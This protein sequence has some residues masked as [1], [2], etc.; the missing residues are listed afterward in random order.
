MKVY[1]INRKDV[2]VFQDGKALKVFKEKKYEYVL[3]KVGED[4][5]FELNFVKKSE[6][7]RPLWWLYAALFWIIGIMGFCT[8]AYSKNTDS[9]N[10][11]M[12]YTGR[13]NSLRVTFY[14][15]NPKYASQGAAL[16]V[17]EGERVLLRNC[18][19]VAN[20]KARSRKK[21]YSLLSG[22][23]RL[24]VIILIIFLGVSAITG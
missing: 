22:F 3:P 10:C 13:G 5:E 21:I 2:I 20:P 14:H 23:A 16:T 7:S 19:Y 4:N 12:K 24:G 15:S 18:S 17:D 8:S 11:S 1:L 6:F 9:L